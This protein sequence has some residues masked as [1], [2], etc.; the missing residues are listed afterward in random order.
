MAVER[1]RDWRDDVSLFASVVETDPRSAEGYFNLGSALI[2]RGDTAGARA[3]W[4]RAVGIDPRH[5]G[6]LAQLGTL[7]ARQG[8]L[9]GA[10]ARYLAAVEA[11]PA[12]VMARYNLGRIYEMQGEP[13]RAA[14]Q[15]ELFLRYVPV[16]YGE[17]VPEVQARLAKLRGTAGAAPAP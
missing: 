9:A 1:N 11:N 10:K 14:E 4:E 15:Y 17:Y 2:E 8:D 3:A 12:N 6:A 7:A 16:E 5:S 13:A